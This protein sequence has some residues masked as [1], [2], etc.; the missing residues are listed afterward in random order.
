MTEEEY[1]ILDELYF[2]RSWKDLVEKSDLDMEEQT[3]KEYL[4]RL[5]EKGW[6]AFY[7]SVNKEPAGDLT[8]LP[9]H[10]QHC[11]YLATKAGLLVHTS[12]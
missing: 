8:Q 1:L 4:V 12:K 2:M 3:L 6:I 9:I 10:Y 7:L 5:C 11:F